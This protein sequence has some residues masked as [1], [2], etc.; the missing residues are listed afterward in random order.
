MGALTEEGKGKQEKRRKRARVCLT[1]YVWGKY[2]IKLYM[3][4]KK[5]LSKA[6]YYHL[7]IF[8]LTFCIFCLN[9]Y[10]LDCSKNNDKNSMCKTSAQ[11]QMW[12]LETKIE[13]L[14]KQDGNGSK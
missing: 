14:N 5:I 6:I 11:M 9:C 1:N 13:H 3:G 2:K 10:F 4:Q 12:N 7:Q 8:I